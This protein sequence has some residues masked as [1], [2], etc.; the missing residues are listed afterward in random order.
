MI[1]HNWNL[2]TVRTDLEL[3]KSFGPMYAIL[4]IILT[5]T[6]QRGSN[7][8]KTAQLIENSCEN[9]RGLTNKLL[10]PKRVCMSRMQVHAEQ[11]WMLRVAARLKHE[12]EAPVVR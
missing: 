7:E 11:W 9:S 6:E 3:S 8:K 5:C 12:H 2:G 1:L 4:S 10:M